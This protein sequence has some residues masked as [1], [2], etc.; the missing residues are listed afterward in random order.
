MPTSLLSTQKPDERNG[1]PSTAY[2][3]QKSLQGVQHGCLL[4]AS[5]ILYY[6]R[7]LDEDMALLKAGL[8]STNIAIGGSKIGQRSD[9]LM[10]EITSVLFADARI[11]PHFRHIG[12][13]VDG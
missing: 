8:L 12:V 11:R 1:M 2:S 4:V 6:C 9:N 3:Q 5:T 7:S 13:K 10:S